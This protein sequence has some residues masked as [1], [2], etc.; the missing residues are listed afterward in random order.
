MHN[1]GDASLL[2]MPLF[3]FLP[4]SDPRVVSTVAAIE[5]ELVSDGLVKRYQSRFEVD[6]LPPGEGTFL[7]CTFY[8]NNSR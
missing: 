7:V 6:G 8:A 2:L 5:R 3:G 1:L 4:A